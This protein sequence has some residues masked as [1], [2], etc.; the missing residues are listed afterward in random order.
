MVNYLSSPWLIVLT[1]VVLLFNQFD[2]MLLCSPGCSQTNG[3]ASASPDSSVGFPVCCHSWLSNSIICVEVALVLWNI[4][5][6]S[7]LF[8]FTSVKSHYS[9]DGTGVGSEIPVLV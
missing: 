6:F 4:L 1:G 5:C 9:F 2:L 3:D 7:I 8:F